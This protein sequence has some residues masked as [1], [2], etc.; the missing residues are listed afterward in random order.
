MLSSFTVTI[1]ESTTGVG[2]KRRLS[3]GGA[4]FLAIC[5]IMLFALVFT[6]E[7]RCC[8]FLLRVF[9]DCNKFI[10]CSFVRGFCS[11]GRV[12]CYNRLWFGSWSC[13]LL[14]WFVTVMW[15]AGRM[16]ECDYSTLTYRL[17]WLAYSSVFDSWLLCPCDL[18]VICWHGDSMFCLPSCGRPIMKPDAYTVQCTYTSL[19]SWLIAWGYQQQLCLLDSTYA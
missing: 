2:S 13:V 14:S 7:A 17:G 5:G 3:P 19:S 6:F 4:G 1:W 11:Q 9:C 12:S 18:N 8:H 16:F 10:P 15:R